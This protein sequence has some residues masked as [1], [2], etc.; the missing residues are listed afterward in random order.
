LLLPDENREYL[1]IWDWHGWFNENSKNQ[2]KFYIGPSKPGWQRGIAGDSYLNL[3]VLVAHVDIENNKWNANVDSYVS[4]E[5]AGSLPSH[6]SLI[7]IPAITKQD[8]KDCLGIICFDSKIK[9]TFDNSQTQE[10]LQF[11]SRKVT[12]VLLI[13]QECKKAKQ[14]A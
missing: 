6:H 13:Y 4:F 12:D 8:S 9:E 1:L 7:C 11:I 5:E 14:R 2:I 10:M 3:K